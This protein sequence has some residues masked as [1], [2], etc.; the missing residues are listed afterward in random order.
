LYDTDFD[1][2]AGDILSDPEVSVTGIALG[3][4]SARFH[5][6]LF[7]EDLIDTGT[8]CEPVRRDPHLLA[9]IYYTGGTTGRPK[10]VM[11]SEMALWSSC[12]SSIHDLGLDQTTRCLHAAPIFHIAGGSQAIAMTIVAGCHVCVK[13]FEPRRVL[14]CI[15][16]EQITSTLLVP[17]MIRMLLNH[18]AFD[19]GAAASLERLIYGAAPMS[20]K[21]LL[22]AKRAFPNCQMMQGYGQ[23]EVAALC[24]V[25]RDDEFG[26]DGPENELRP[27]GRAS[28]CV[29][30]RI[31]DEN[32]REVPRGETGEIWV[33]GPNVMLGYWNQ[34]EKTEA[35]LVDGWVKTGD[36]GHMDETGY[37]YISDRLKDMVITGGENVF[38]V[39]VEDALRSH[40]KVQDVA[41]IGVPDETYGERVH[42]I[43][44]PAAGVELDPAE[45]ISHCRTLIAGFKVPRSVEIRSEPLPLSAAGKVLKN[46]LRKAHWAGHMRGVN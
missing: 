17:T 46:D 38:S 22:E 45:I 9:G 28:Y 19:Q 1:E 14:A 4:K 20:K 16:D 40:A 32:G 25:V 3:P 13:A 5:D 11:L 15:R 44:V 43:I 39:E 36:A 37:L 6:V 34:P 26:Y 21:T 41:V 8:W 24:A 18:E 29:N 7:A 23:T 35:Q 42:A 27:V 33:S 12:M 30:V 31:C 10:G 2:L